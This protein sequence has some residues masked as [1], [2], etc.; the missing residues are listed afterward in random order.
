MSTDREKLEKDIVLALRQVY[1]PDI[2]VNVYDL[3]LIYEIRV[4]E[5]NKVFIKMTLTSPTCPLADTIIENVHEAVSE[6]P[7]VESASIELVFEPQWD[8]SMMSEEAL[9]QLGLL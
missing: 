8:K 7:G 6:T 3:G 2:D 4:E 1:D 9:L 5:N